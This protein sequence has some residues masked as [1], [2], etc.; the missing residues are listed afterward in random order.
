MKI[1]ESLLLC[2]MTITSLCMAQVSKESQI[3]SAVL[4]APEEMRESAKVL[5]YE[6]GKIVV[7]REGNGDLVCQADD[8]NRNGFSVSCYQKG[9]EKFMER[10]RELRA[11][12]LERSE[13]F[14][15][16]GKEMEAGKLK[17]QEG[18]TLHILYGADEVFNANTG[19]VTGAKYRF[20]V[21]VP[22]ATTESTGLPL[23]PAS[24]GA[25]WL[26]DA[27]SHRA[28]IMITPMN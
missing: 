9:L 16:R 28:H 11:E 21:Y 2:L 24:P 8:P 25:P 12:G 10:G 14:A 6:E 17:I 5:G 1:K 18:S 15:A 23:K 13:V 7:L 19:E 3:K 27:G 20:V 22:Y 26:M 4:A